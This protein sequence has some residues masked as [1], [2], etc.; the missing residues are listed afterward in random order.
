MT[1][2]EGE[3]ELNLIDDEFENDMHLKVYRELFLVQG[4]SRLLV[5]VAHGFIELMV[6][7][8]CDHYLKNGKKITSDSRSYLH[9]SKL[10][11]LNEVGVID[12]HQ[13]KIYD[14]FRRLRN[15]AA[16]QP[17]FDIEK[18]DLCH[19]RNEK[20]HDPE[21]FFSLCIILISSL[22]NDHTKVLTPIFSSDV[23]DD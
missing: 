20:Y 3:K 18:K 2:R 5:L 4:H 9:S 11:I 13:Y 14:W 12:D 17:I 19:L 7:T 6:N 21:N 8:L 1:D 22:W 16:H 15:K 10:I 23:L